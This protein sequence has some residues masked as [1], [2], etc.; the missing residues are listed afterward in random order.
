MCCGP[1]GHG[2]SFAKTNK[3]RPSKSKRRFICVQSLD[4]TLSFFEQELFTVFIKIYNYGASVSI[5]N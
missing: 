2:T 4:G 3:D 1:F 5:K